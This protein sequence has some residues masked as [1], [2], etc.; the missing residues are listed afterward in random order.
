MKSQ[1]IHLQYGGTCRYNNRIWFSNFGFNGLFSINI[2]DLSVK[3]EY[4][5]PCLKEAVKTAYMHAFTQY[6]GKLCF[7]PNNCRHIFIYDVNNGSSH[8]IAMDLKN[9]EEI[10]ITIEILQ[11][12]DKVWIFP[13]ISRQGV[14]TLNLSTLQMEQDME[15][16]KLVESIGEG[17]EVQIKKRSET[18]AA[19]FQFGDNRITVIDIENKKK[20]SQKVFEENIK[21]YNVFYDRDSCWILQNDSA[22]IYEW[23]QTEDKVIKYCLTEA[24]WID[25][26]QGMPYSSMI[27]FKEH[28]IVLNSRL[29]Y[30]MKID[31]VTQTIKKAFD[32]PQG[33]D[34]QI[35]N[36]YGRWM[37]F[38]VFDVIGNK[39][40]I[41]PVLGN[42]LLIY[43]VENDHVEGKEITVT[44][45]QI[46]YWQKIIEDEFKQGVCIEADNLISSL[47]NFLNVAVAP[48]ESDNIEPTINI[49]G[50][51]YHAVQEG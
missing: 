51:I 15:L 35:N 45:E 7:F 1:V 26:D 41:H 16:S 39:I 40:W 10:Y 46:P 21:I 11:M 44:I 43:D 17:A 24:E 37:A 20:I 9:D 49:G 2:E 14:Y 29:K 48:G 6:D 19:V 13:A 12:H 42:M 34:F 28:I 33:F 50:K 38:N 27:F 18:E 8:E 30:I 5:I 47:E 23:R 25:S 4:K 31:K 32:Y 36:A 3:H 22:D